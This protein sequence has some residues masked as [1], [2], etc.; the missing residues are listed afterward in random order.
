LSALR[1]GLRDARRRADVGLAENGYAAP[2]TSSPSVTAERD[3]R[4]EVLA[5]WT[6]SF[7][8]HARREPSGVKVGLAEVNEAA[9]LAKSR[10][11]VV[12]AHDRWR[13]VWVPETR[14]GV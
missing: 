4:S 9:L 8:A 5:K 14:F 10:L 12:G 2:A 7:F 11:E 6:P 3:P 1:A 13:I